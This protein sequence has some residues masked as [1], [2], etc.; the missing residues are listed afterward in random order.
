[1]QGI[2]IGVVAAFVVL[3][4]IIG[5][6]Y[7]GFLLP[8]FLSHLPTSTEN[9]VRTLS[10]TKLHLS[11][12]RR[13]TISRKRI[14]HHEARMKRGA[15][16]KSSDMTAP[17]SSHFHPILSFCIWLKLI[18]TSIHKVEGVFF[19]MP[20]FVLTNY[21]LI[22]GASECPDTYTWYRGELLKWQ[23]LCLRSRSATCTGL[24]GCIYRPYLYKYIMELFLAQ[25]ERCGDREVESMNFPEFAAS[26]CISKNSCKLRDRWYLN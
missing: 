24:S 10:N 1:M 12:A 13:K 17:L 11:K 19:F 2:F 3:I 8:F 18:T 14:L 20:F 23:A 16:T 21:E 15:F 25:T 9:T 7:A 4:T 26:L 22:S 6:E 5:P